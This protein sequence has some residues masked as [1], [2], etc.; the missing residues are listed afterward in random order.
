[1]IPGCNQK[2]FPFI[3][4]PI[5]TKTLYLFKSERQHK[6]LEEIF[7]VSFGILDQSKNRVQPL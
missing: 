3:T 2:P 7:I 1:M 5:Q 4:A 6:E